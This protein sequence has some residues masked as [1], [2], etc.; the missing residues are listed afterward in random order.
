M[1]TIPISDRTSYL[2]IDQ[3]RR[4]ATMAEAVAA[5][6]AL[7]ADTTE[8]SEEAIA[9]LIEAL[10]HHHPSV[11][12]AAVNGLVQLAPATVEPLITAFETVSDQ[13]VQAYIIQAL[14]RIGDARAVELL[15]EVVGVS[16]A[17]HCQG[18]VRRVAARGLGHIGRLAND[19]EIIRQA[20]DKLTWAL[21]NPEDWG[22]RYAAVVSL[23][24]MASPEVIPT[25]EQALKK[26]SDQV[27]R[28]RLERAI[29]QLRV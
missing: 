23:E 15:A 6:E 8:I 3:F 18:N 12:V 17:N 10:S 25:L 19:P 2:L 21:L 24:D 4:A 22:L 9:V 5:I 14:A 1:N 28:V 11:A 26:E 27:V 16:V 7:V 29:A 13:G 20:V